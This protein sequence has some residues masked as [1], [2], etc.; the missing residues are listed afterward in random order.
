MLNL[1][2]TFGKLA[3]Q[4]VF[5][6]TPPPPPPPPCIL[7][8]FWYH[9]A[10]LPITSSLESVSSGSLC[11]SPLCITQFFGSLSASRMQPFVSLP[12]SD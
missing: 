7:C 11:A 5:T 4:G 3:T 1:V 2:E 9:L 10:P 8:L 12:D 6:V